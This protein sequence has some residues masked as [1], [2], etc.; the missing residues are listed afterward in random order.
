MTASY[1][2][3]IPLKQFTVEKSAQLKK[4]KSL[5]QN[6]LIFVWFHA[7]NAEPWELPLVDEVH[8]GKWKFHGYNE[9]LIKC[10]IQDIPENGA[11]V[12]ELNKFSRK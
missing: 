6:G 12:G 11:D 9:F 10:H 5:E 1:V 3:Q 7:E 8:S 2:T 4:W